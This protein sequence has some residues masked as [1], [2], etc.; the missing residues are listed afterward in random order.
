MQSLWIHHS[1]SSEVV[2]VPKKTMRKGLYMFDTNMRLL[3]PDDCF[4]A[5]TADGTDTILLTPQREFDVDDQEL[6][7]AYVL[8]YT[9]I[10]DS[11][12]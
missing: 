12:R 5:V 4:E 11:E 2:R 6:D 8:A 7:S 3:G 1:D 9:A 10:V